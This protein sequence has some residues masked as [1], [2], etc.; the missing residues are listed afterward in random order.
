VA[1]P[2]TGLT[3]LL[4]QGERMLDSVLVLAG[5]AAPAQDRGPGAA[6]T[7]TGGMLTP[8]TAALILFGILFGAARA[9]R[10]GCLCAGLACLPMFLIEE[11]L[12]MQNLVQETFN[13]YNSFI[14]LAVPFFLLTRT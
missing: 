5:R 4:F 6:A 12:S 14:L 11:R 3:W 1:W 13:A 10:A 2:V 8:G 7:M 9:A